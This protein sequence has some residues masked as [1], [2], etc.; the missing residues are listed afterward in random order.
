MAPQPCLESGLVIQ[1]ED[2][3]LSFTPMFSQLSCEILP[4]R[5]SPQGDPFDLLTDAGTVSGRLPLSV[6]HQ[7]YHV[8]QQICELGL[9]FVTTSLADLL[10]LRAVGLPAGLAKGLENI[11]GHALAKLRNA[12]G[13]AEPGPATPAGDDEATPPPSLA[14]TQE[15]GAP[16]PQPEEPSG[17]AS[18][19]PSALINPPRLILVGWSP[20]RLGCQSPGHLDWVISTIMAI[21]HYLGVDLDEVLVWRPTPQE[22]QRITFGLQK[23]ERQDVVREILK[24]ID[25]S[26]PP[27]T[28]SP[29][30]KEATGDFL[31]SRASLH[32]ALVQPGSSRRLRRRLLLKHQKA[33]E[34]TFVE[35]LLCRRSRNRT[36]MSGAGCRVWRKSLACSISVRSCSWPSSN[37]RSCAMACVAMGTCWRPRT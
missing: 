19:T 7:D 35:P 12:W 1:G 33:V 32:K 23:G 5:A 4:L 8:F 27:L 24:S 9:L 15:D 20:S 29:S 28:P 10:S 34:S 16:Q 30:D 3:T 36:P 11:T 2:E 6:A 25:R 22:T 21:A 31:A 17:P 18:L 13:A 37:G 26:A 14:D